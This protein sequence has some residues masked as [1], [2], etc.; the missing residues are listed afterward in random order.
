M[1]ALFSQQSFKGGALLLR[2][3]LQQAFCAGNLAVLMGQF[4][5]QALTVAAV[6]I[7]IRQGLCRR[8]VVLTSA[9]QPR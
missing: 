1:A 6:K 4:G 7:L 5:L 9:P 3:G 2:Q 8:A